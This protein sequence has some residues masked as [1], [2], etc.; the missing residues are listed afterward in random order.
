MPSRTEKVSGATFT[1][2][3][4]VRS[5]PLK[6]AVKPVG[7]TFSAACNAMTAKNGVKKSGASFMGWVQESLVA[8][9][10]LRQGRLAV[11]FGERIVRE[12]GLR[13]RDDLKPP[14]ARSPG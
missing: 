2:I 3:Q 5:L 4:P 11:G 14:A 9:E 8:R 7:A 13:L 6:S 10:F 12:V 1:G